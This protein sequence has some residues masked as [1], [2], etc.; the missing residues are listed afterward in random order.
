[1][2][3]PNIISPSHSLRSPTEISLDNADQYEYKV[4]NN[5]EMKE[6]S[7]SYQIKPNE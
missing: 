5:G 7:Q 3:N 2:P 1:M 6:I 4:M